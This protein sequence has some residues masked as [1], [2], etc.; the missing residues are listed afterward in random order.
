MPVGTLG[1][2]TQAPTHIHTRGEVLLVAVAREK[3]EPRLL[4]CRGLLE[5]EY[6]CGISE[7]TEERK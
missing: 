4:L 7:K 3:L 5:C 2:R 1:L 6:Y